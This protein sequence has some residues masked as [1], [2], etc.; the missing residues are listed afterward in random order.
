VVNHEVGHCLGLPHTDGPGVMTVDFTKMGSW[1]T[2]EEI[3]K[4]RGNID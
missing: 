2:D 3:A 1:P 4:A